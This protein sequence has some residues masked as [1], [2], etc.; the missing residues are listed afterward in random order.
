MGTH[1]ADGAEEQSERDGGRLWLCQPILPGKKNTATYDAMG[2]LSK[3]V[4]QSRNAERDGKKVDGV[5]SPCKPA[6]M[7]VVRQKDELG[8]TKRTQKRKAPTASMSRTPRPATMAF[9]RPCLP[10]W[11]LDF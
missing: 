8:I 3:L 4:L 2:R 11:E 5:A 10:A 7:M 6:E 9:V 1:S